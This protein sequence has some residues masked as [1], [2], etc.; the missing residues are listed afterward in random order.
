MDKT[1]GGLKEDSPLLVAVAGCREKLLLTNSGN[2]GEGQRRKASGLETRHPWKQ[3]V[4]L[5]EGD[6]SWKK[7]LKK[8][9]YTMMVEKDPGV[10]VDQDRNLTDSLNKHFL[11]TRSK[12]GETL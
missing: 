1:H 8:W 9:L 2:A 7:M 3:E 10:L 5:A 4:D 11:R 12:R 6:L